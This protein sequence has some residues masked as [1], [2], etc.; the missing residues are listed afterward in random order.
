MQKSPL[1]QPGTTYRPHSLRRTLLGA[2]LFALTLLVG[3]GC[4]KSE[5]PGPMG[6]VLVYTQKSASTF[7]KIDVFVDGELAGTLTL[8]FVG[9]LVQPK[10][11][12]GTATTASV[13]NVQR[14]VGSSHLIEAKGSLK[15]KAAGSW[16]TTAKF[17]SEEC[18]RVR[19][20]E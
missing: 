1:P 10:P 7:D 9:T 15:G 18:F 4:K 12:C 19:L 6:S 13:L 5:D 8:P 2:A 14:P 20:T 11:L 3:V 16:K 17:E